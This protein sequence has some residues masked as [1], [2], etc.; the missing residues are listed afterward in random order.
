[1][2]LETHRRMQQVLFADGSAAG[3][4]GT[5]Y[6]QHL[7][8]K[9]IGGGDVPYA[10]LYFP[11]ELGGLGLRNPFISFLVIREQLRKSPEERM[12]EFFA[13]EK[14][15]YNRFKKEFDA[16]GALGRKR[17]MKKI[18]ESSVGIDKRYV[19]KNPSPSEHHPPSLT[20]R[21]LKKASNTAP[22]S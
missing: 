21:T 19:K 9:R 12:A 4:S 18:W 11:E 5:A 22:I 3:S 13:E 7:I 10:F 16:L 15:D 6:L 2:I 8:T 17:R 14:A 20:N 1:M